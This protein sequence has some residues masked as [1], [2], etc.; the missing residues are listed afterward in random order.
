MMDTNDKMIPKVE[1]FYATDPLCSFCWAFEPTLRKFHYQYGK[2]I[3]TYTVVMGGMIEDWE[4]FGG[5]GANGITDAVD[6]AKHW[7]EIGDY[8]RMVIDGRIWLEEPIASSFPSSQTYEIVRRDYPAQAPLYLRRLREAVMMWNQDVSKTE[9][10]RTIL[11][12]MDFDAEPILKDAES[13]EGRTLLNGDIGLSQALTVTGFP[14][15]VMV[16]EQNQGIKIVGAQSFDALVE[17]LRQVL[18]EGTELMPE[19]VPPLDIVME[20]HPLLLNKEI[21]VLYDLSEEEVSQFVKLTVGKENVQIG[22]HLGQYYYK[23]I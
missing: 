7:R 4:T 3:N 11:E 14:T 18:P 6:V 16:N 19:P 15:L 9:V 20:E 12:E 1:V 22:Q 8:T 13:F 10:L 23:K 17:A 5:D 21:E 2:H